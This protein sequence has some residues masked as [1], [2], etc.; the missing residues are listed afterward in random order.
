M[1]KAEREREKKSHS[2]V[3]SCW[4][5]F[6]FDSLLLLPVSLVSERGRLLVWADWL[7]QNFFFR[8]IYRSNSKRRTVL[9][10]QTSPITMC[11]EQYFPY[12]QRKW[13]KVNIFQKKSFFIRRRGGSSSKPAISSSTERAGDR[14]VV[15]YHNLNF[16]VAIQISCELGCWPSHRVNAPGNHERRSWTSGATLV[17]TILALWCTDTSLSERERGHCSPI[18][19]SCRS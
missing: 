10:S 6:L 7:D 13:S 11:Y 16:I 18:Q 12:L 3:G 15:S 19:I 14:P 4:C 2:T 8:S 17:S 9:Y 1:L 5:N